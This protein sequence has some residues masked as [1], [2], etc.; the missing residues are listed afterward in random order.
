MRQQAEDRDLT[1]LLTTHSPV[2]MNA[3]KGYEDQFY[4]LSQPASPEP[5]PRSLDELYDKDW[6]AHF[7]LGDLYER[8]K[9]VAPVRGPPVRMHPLQAAKPTLAKPTLQ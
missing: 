7:V 9:I 6:L 1:I 4:V 2:V 8:E 3:F 5:V